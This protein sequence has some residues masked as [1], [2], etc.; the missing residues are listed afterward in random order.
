MEIGDKG[1]PI[2]EEFPPGTADTE[3]DDDVHERDTK[4]DGPP[5]LLRDIAGAEI[6]RS[7]TGA[8]VGQTATDVRG[9]RDHEGRDEWRSAGSRTQCDEGGIHAG[10]MGTHAGEEIMAVQIDDKGQDQCS[11]HADA[12]QLILKDLGEPGNEA[13]TVQIVGHDDDAANPDQGIPGF[14][15]AR[16][17]APFEHAADEQDAEAHEGDEGGIKMRHAGRS[18][19]AEQHD[20]NTQQEHTIYTNAKICYRKHTNFSDSAKYL[21]IK[22]I[23][24]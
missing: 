3:P 12:D 18:P 21:I 15:L 13:E 5:G 4:A 16:D 10:D 8:E 9:N 20:E 23:I 7:R 6:Y 2:A 24:A 11:D 14:L 19:E 22:P 1:L 17:V